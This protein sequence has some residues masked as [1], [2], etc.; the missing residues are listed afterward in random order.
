MTCLIAAAAVAAVRD[1]V[2]REFDETGTE[3]LNPANIP[4]I[5]R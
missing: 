3:R 5:N 2:W 4:D 1:L